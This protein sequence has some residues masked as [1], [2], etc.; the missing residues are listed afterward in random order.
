MSTPITVTII[1]FLSLTGILQST[2]HLTR[3]IAWQPRIIW[4]EEDDGG[5]RRIV[6][7]SIFGEMEPQNL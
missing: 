4:A 2:R 7:E 3:A 5:Q 6:S 1:T